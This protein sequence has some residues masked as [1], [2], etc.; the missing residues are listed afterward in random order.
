MRILQRSSFATFDCLIREIAVANVSMAL[1]YSPAAASLTA[2][3]I[4]ELLTV[5]F[6][7]MISSNS[8]SLIGG[9]TFVGGISK[10]GP[11]ILFGPPNIGLS[12]CW[13]KWGGA[14]PMFMFCCIGGP[15]PILFWLKNAGFTCGAGPWF[16][17]ICGGPLGGIFMPGW[18]WL[19][20][21]ECIGRFPQ[22]GR[23]P[24]GGIFIGPPPIGRWFM[25]IGFIFIGGRFGPMPFGPIC[26]GGPFQLFW[27]R[28]G[29][30]ICGPFG[31]PPIG[32]GPFP[33]ILCIGFCI[34]PEFCIIGF[35]PRIMGF[36]FIIRCWCMF[37]GGIFCIG[38]P[39]PIPIPGFWLFGWAGGVG[40]VFCWLS[41]WFRACLVGN[42]TTG[43]WPF[44]SF[45]GKL[46]M[47]ILML[48]S[49]PS[50]I[51]QK[52]FDWPLARFSK[53]FTSWK[54]ET[55]KPITASVKSWSVVHQ[56][57]LPT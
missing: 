21:P 57:R 5:L 17:G 11:G 38:P 26:L 18:G 34:G 39:M 6:R 4:A 10:P 12:P 7:P 30:F 3:A 51:T 8:A 56:V 50:V 54:S 35:G 32:G 52:P 25:F 14:P 23:G 31:W 44:S 15:W 29:I 22:S 49:D 2:R 55:P 16:I 33:G 19:K 48:F 40:R 53:N 27:K 28:G 36:G 43:F 13:L 1:A 45:F 46:S 9:W 20:F 37:W 24:R 47:T 42:V 41:N